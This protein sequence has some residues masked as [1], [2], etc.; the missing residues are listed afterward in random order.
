MQGVLASQG[1]H[2]AQSRVGTSLQRV[3]PGGHS[4]RADLSERQRNPTPYFA[5]YFENCT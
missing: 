1:Y 2:V 4:R 3:N 5:R